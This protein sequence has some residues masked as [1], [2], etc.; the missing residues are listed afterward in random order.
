MFLKYNYFPQLYTRGQNPQ[1]EQ[2][3]SSMQLI[4]KELLLI[5]TAHITQTIRLNGHRSLS[6]FMVYREEAAT[7]DGR[8]VRTLPTHTTTPGS[9]TE[10][11]L[12]FFLFYYFSFTGSS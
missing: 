3:M 9:T 10:L 5:L 8:A 4:H 12:L 7:A 6:N 1:A 2:A 11:L